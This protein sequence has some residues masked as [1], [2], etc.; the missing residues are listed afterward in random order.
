MDESDFSEGNEDGEDAH[1]EVL[2]PNNP[3]HAF[4]ILERNFNKVFIGC[5]M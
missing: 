1:E 5:N 3:E 2:D 4:A